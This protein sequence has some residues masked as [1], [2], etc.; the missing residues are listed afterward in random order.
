MTKKEEARKLWEMCFDDFPG[1]TELYFK[2][3]YTDQNTIA[4]YRDDQMVSVLQL[5]S[6]PF[7]F[8]NQTSKSAYISG[9]CTHIDYRNKGAMHQ[10]LVES[11]KHLNQTNVPICTLIPAEE[12][13][14][15]YYQKTGFETL[16]YNSK[17]ELQL[18][19][20]I[21]NDDVVVSFNNNFDAQTYE[22]FNKMT[23]QRKAVLL[24]PEKDMEVVMDDL[25]MAEGKLFIARKHTQI[26]G[27]LFAYFDPTQKTIYVNE[28]LADNCD[29]KQELFKGAAKY[30]GSDK[31]MVTAPAY[32]LPKQPFGMLRIVQALPILKV[33]AQ[34]NP[35][36]QDE[37]ILEDSIIG[38]NQGTYKIEKSR[39]SFSSK[40]SKKVIKE[41]NINELAIELFDKLNPYMSLMLD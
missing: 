18:P 35:S 34:A 31:L 15:G 33:F 2:K 4:V 28:V 37:F 22:Y 25:I 19:N 26:L 8:L 14:F 30:F 40:R 1:F 12:W 38:E 21:T 20:L 41:L 36:W 3:R 39:V 10:L 23:R 29:I 16:F 24:H 13:L 9:A 32:H 17:F 5:L 27:L 6:Y 11:L 7:Y